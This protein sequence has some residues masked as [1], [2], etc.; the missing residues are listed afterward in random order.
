MRDLFKSAD[1]VVNGPSVYSGFLDLGVDSV[2]SGFLRDTV[3]RTTDEMPRD[4][5]DLM[6]VWLDRNFYP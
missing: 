1:V 5:E 4:L 3:L 6:F 2:T